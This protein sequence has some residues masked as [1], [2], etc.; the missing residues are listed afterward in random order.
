MIICWKDYL[1]ASPRRQYDLSEMPGRTRRKG[2]RDEVTAIPQDRPWPCHVAP[3]QP[4]HSA[5]TGPFFM[6]TPCRPESS[7]WRHGQI[8]TAEASAKPDGMSASIKNDE[9]LGLLVDT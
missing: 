2:L 9:L 5:A 3:W 8:I 6:R 7:W 4:N 1:S